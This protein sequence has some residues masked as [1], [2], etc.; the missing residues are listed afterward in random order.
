[1]SEAPKNH[2]H[3]THT[4]SFSFVLSWHEELGKLNQYSFSYELDDRGLI[5]GR[6]R[7]FSLR[8]RAQTG[9]EGPPSLLTS[10]HPEGFLRGVK[11][12]GR[13]TDHLHLVSKSMRI[14]PLIRLHGV[15]LKKHGT[16]VPYLILI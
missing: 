6:G 15:V 5:P 13:D 16:A 10:E 4:P 8:H 14:P 9:S 7:Y 1:M 11:R 12:P 2:P 3:Q